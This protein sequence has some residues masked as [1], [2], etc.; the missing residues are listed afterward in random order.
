MTVA[1][2]THPACAGHDPG[3]GHP[4]RPARLRAVLDALDTPHLAS[5]R[6]VV[7]REA[8]RAQLAR[9]HDGGFLDALFAV[10]D[11]PGQLVPLDADTAMGD[12]S[13]SAALLAAGAAC[14]AVDLVQG[15]DA[16]FAFAATRP[17][18][19]HAEPNRAMGFCL[20]SNAAVA[21]RHAR[22][23][24]GLQ[25]IA[26]VDFDVHHGN[27]TQAAAHDDPDFFFA[28]SHQSPCYPGTGRASEH[29]VAGNV[30]NVPLPPGTGGSVFLSAWRETILPALVRFGPE[31]VILSAGFDAHRADPLAALEL[32]EGDFHAVTTMIVEAAHGR[33]VS[34]LEGGYDLD[35]L[36]ASARAHVE[37]LVAADAG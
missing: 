15:G 33:L 35:A 12:G 23:A 10:G 2:V 31:L 34:L 8:T 30:V 20:F 24:H 28:S 27:G 14:Q 3:P 18:G 17:P 9:V 6:R 4:E 37:A 5:L 19:H 16:R 36:A 21:A 11:A 29:G 32:D 1:L 13:L 26:V 22:A 7:A 25:R